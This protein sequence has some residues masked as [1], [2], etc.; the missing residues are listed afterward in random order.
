MLTIAVIGSKDSGKTTV[1]EVLIRELTRKGYKVATV[2]HIPEQ[3]F[4]IDTEGKDTWRHAKAGA[5]KVIS[6]APKEIAVIHKVETEK[7]SLDDIL[8]HCEDADIVIL[9]G[10]KSL[11]GTNPEILKIVTVKNPEE[12][13]E[14]SKIF[15]PIIAFSGAAANRLSKENFAIPIIDA[16]NETEKLV[17]LVEEKIG[18]IRKESSENFALYVDNRQI[19][20][21]PFVQRI[22]KSSIIAMASTLKGVEVS[23]NDKVIVKIKKWGNS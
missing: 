23:P 12:A 17:K 5:S 9:E 19:S 6:V 13:R 4:T 21:K 10:F 15:R 1:T 7:L 3:N 14:A 16:L 20:L 8:Q 11:I 18:Q 22:M 2:K